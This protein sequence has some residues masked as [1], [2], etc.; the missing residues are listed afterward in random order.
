MSAHAGCDSHI[1]IGAVFVL[2]GIAKGV[3]G[4]GLPTVSMGLRAVV[5][6]P[7]QAAASRHSSLIFGN[8]L[9][10]RP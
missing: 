5:M 1:F 9:L 2:A 3:T 8:W 4:L 6:T 10:A 7:L